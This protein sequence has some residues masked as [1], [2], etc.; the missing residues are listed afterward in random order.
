MWLFS[1][2]PNQYGQVL[3]EAGPVLAAAAT[4][5]V[6][7]ALQA[8]ALV[9]RQAFMVVGFEQSPVSVI[10]TIPA[11]VSAAGVVP[12]ISTTVAEEWRL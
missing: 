5:A 9:P 12:R 7:A 2:L 1:V 11:E 6:A 4:L 10:H 8:A 3:T